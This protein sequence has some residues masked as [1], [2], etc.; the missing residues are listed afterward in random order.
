[1][2]VPRIKH[3][4]AVKILSDILKSFPTTENAQANR[5]KVVEAVLTAI[6]NADISNS[7]ANALIN[8]IVEDFPKYS[9]IQ[10]VRLVDYCLNSIR[11]NDDNFFRL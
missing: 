5:R 10:L 7:D 8:R 6:K 2:I 9:K 11:V 1:M 3:N 4:H